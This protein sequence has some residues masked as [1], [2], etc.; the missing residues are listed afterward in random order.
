MSIFF[1]IVIFS[2]LSTEIVAAKFEHN[3]AEVKDYFGCKPCKTKVCPPVP[4]NDECELVVENG[5]CGC[6]LVCARQEGDM[7]G[8]F[9][10]PCQSPLQ[11]VPPPGS[12]INALFSGKGKCMTSHRS[13]I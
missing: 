11:C 8:T 1:S 10:E 4:N 12:S 2:V 3:S 5:V 7:C 9:T 6:C 13:G